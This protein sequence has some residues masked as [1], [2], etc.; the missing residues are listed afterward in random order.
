[1]RIF[2]FAAV[3]YCVVG[4]TVR[5]LAASAASDQLRNLS[6]PAAWVI[7]AAVFGAHVVHV[8]R[9]THTSLVLGAAHVSLAVAAAAVILAALGLVRTLWGDPDR[10]TAAFFSLLIWPAVTAVPAFVLALAGGVILRR[11]MPQAA[12]PVN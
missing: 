5:W 11:V 6:W 9:R 2:A 1:M 12:P 8:S 4:L 10:Q 3:T 7:S